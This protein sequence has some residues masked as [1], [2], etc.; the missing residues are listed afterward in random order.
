MYSKAKPLYPFGY[1][2]S[3]TTFEY[4]KLKTRSDA[5]ARDGSLTIRV[6]VKNTGDRAGEEVV[7]L[8]VRHVDS[9][10]DRPVKELRGFRRVALQPGETKTV[11]LPLKADALAYWNQPQHA[12]V[13]EADKVELSVGGSSADERLKT[14]IA[15]Q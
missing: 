10:V 5:L 7:Q 3:Y 8:Y 1:G 11:E 15:V 2:L 6:D 14:R 9:K 4:S 13:V 12:F